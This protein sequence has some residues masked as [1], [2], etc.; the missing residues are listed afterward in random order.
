MY[1]RGTCDDALYKLMF[2]LLTY[3]YEAA[4]FG[5]IIGDGKRKYGTF[6]GSRHC[7]LVDD[8]TQKCGDFEE[9]SGSLA[10]MT[11]KNRYL[12]RIMD[13]HCRV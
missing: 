13:S 1:I 7:Q 5:A 4:K 11:V 3:Y 8:L 6:M 9:I 10:N 2:Y 12:L